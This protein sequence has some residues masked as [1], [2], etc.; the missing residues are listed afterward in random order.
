MNKKN[1]R[2]SAVILLFTVIWMISGY[3]AQTEPDEYV[4]PETKEVVLVNTSKASDYRLPVTV[5]AESQAF[6]KVDVRSQTSEKIINIAFADGDFVKES[7]VICKLDSG[8]RE[9]NFKKSKID[10][11]SSVELNKKGLISESALVTAETMYES[12]KIELERTEIRAPFDG[13]V[14][15]LAKQGQ[16]LQNGQSC[17]SI[18]SLTPLKIVGNVSEMMVAKIKPGLDAEINFISGEKYNTKVSFISSAADTRTRTFKVEAELENTDLN[19]KDGLTG[20]LIIYTQPVKAH[21]IP[22]SAFLLG[23]QGNVALATVLNDVVKIIDVQILMDTVQGAWIT[24]LPDETNV[25]I[26]GQGFVKEGDE[27]I[28]KFR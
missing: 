1:L 26:G 20:E 14:E 19:I 4:A 16:L 24:G 22:T 15:N 3:F 27:V 11:D 13:Y 28:S 25:I 23:D 10:Y 12:A 21:F 7:E 18:I 6:S 8:Q 9:A 2:A 5:K 17:A